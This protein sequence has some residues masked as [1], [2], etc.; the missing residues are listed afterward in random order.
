M[1]YIAWRWAVDTF[2]FLVSVTA[3]REGQDVLLHLLLPAALR[4]PV[5]FLFTIPPA[6]LLQQRAHLMHDRREASLDIGGARFEYGEE[7]LARAGRRET[8]EIA[9]RESIEKQ[10]NYGVIIGVQSDVLATRTKNVKISVISN[11]MTSKL[12]RWT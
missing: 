7:L 5:R 12:V 8:S 4:Q 11:P 2:T 10:L 3:L 1:A 9:A 6:P